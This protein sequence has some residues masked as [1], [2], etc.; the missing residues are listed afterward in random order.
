VLFQNF[1]YLVFC[2]WCYNDLMRINK[3]LALCRAGSR[4]GVE[5]I[6]LS[7]RVKVNGVVVTNLATDISDSDTVTVDDKPVIAQTEKVYIMINKPVGVITTAKDPEGRKTVLDIIYEN[8]KQYKELLSS[9]RLFPAGRLDYNTGGL[10]II[11]NDGD[12]TRQLTHPSS[13][14]TKTYIAT[15][16]EPITETQ[17]NTLSNGVM[18]CTEHGERKSQQ[19]ANSQGLALGSGLVPIECRSQ[20]STSSQN[21]ER[22]SQQSANSQNG[23]HQQ[24]KIKINSIK[25]APA[26]FEYLPHSEKIKITIHEG[27]N[28]QIRKMFES[29][30]ANVKTLQRIAEGKLTLGNLKVGEWR[31]VRK[32]EIL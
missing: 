1:L 20:Q 3:Y 18:I 22:K 9:V 13:E 26:K 17:L 12:L 27:R 14:I 31:F 10:L 4:R 19:S 23:G 8:P 29:I 7:K 32:S 21:G 2:F 5:E 16:D 15:T 24:N 28:R 11:T 25:T 30:G 6:I